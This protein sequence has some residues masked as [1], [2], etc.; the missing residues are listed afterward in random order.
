MISL[1]SSASTAARSANTYV[2]VVLT[3][4]L[5]DSSQMKYQRPPR[6]TAQA[7]HSLESVA[8]MTPQRAQYG[9]IS[10]PMEW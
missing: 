2:H 7:G 1:D 10:W 8:G 9:V 6:S 4:L 3:R 5:W